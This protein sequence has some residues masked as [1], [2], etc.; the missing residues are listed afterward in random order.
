MLCK[1]AAYDVF[2]SKKSGESGNNTFLGWLILNY[3]GDQD[4]WLFKVQLQENVE[5]LVSCLVNICSN[6]TLLSLYC[7]DEVIFLLIWD[8]ASVIDFNHLSNVYYHTIFTN[9]CL[10]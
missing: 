9:I 2:T 5:S 8:L 4:F 1:N 10:I 7:F 3:F 6:D